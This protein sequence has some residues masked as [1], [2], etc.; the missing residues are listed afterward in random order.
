MRVVLDTNILLQAIAHNSRLRPIWNAFLNEVFE[1]HLTTAILLEYEELL[2]Q[3]ASEKAAAFVV[4]AIG[5]APNVRFIAI[6]Y[7]WNAIT[8]DPDD[9]KFFDAAV[10]ANANYLVTNDNHFN[11]VKTLVF[12]KISIIS[13]DEFLKLL[14]N[15][16][17]I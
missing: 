9:N 11:E 16:N 3:K 5:N 14:A 15:S 1:L 10:A 12:P 8:T 2:S 7:N 6:Y 4:S 17:S 13:A